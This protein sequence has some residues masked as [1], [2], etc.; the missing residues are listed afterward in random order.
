MLTIDSDTPFAFLGR[1][2]F[3]TA[4]GFL[5]DMAVRK[6]NFCNRIKVLTNRQKDPFEVY[7]YITDSIEKYNTEALFS[8]FR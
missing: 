5:L 1:N 3:R 2:I 8:S 7:D 6:D 4:G